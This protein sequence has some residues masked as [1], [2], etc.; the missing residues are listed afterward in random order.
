MPLPAS[1][2][3]VVGCSLTAIAAGERKVESLGCIP[4]EF[5]YL[6]ATAASRFLARCWERG[7]LS[8]IAA[9]VG[10]SSEWHDPFISAEGLEEYGASFFEN[11]LAN[12]QSKLLR[13]TRSA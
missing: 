9:N 3:P 6:A 11:Y 13:L 10:F 2:E 8:G 7:F 12:P 1:A 5:C 4:G